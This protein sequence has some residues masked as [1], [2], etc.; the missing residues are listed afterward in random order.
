MTGTSRQRNPVNG[1]LLLDK[2]RG[3]TSQQAVSRVKRLFSA[4]KAGHA[5]TLDPM[6]EGLLPIGLGEAT[7]F[8]QF[9]LDAD[10]CYLATLRL[11]ITTRSGDAEGEILEQK[12]VTMEKSGV[13]AVLH[14]F[15]G[16]QEQTPPMHSAIKIAGK[17]LYAYARAG[18]ELERKSRTIRINELQLIDY[19][20]ENIT[21][22]VHCSKG[23]YIRVLAEDIGAALG[24]GAHL[25][26]LVRE[27][28]GAFRLVDA[29]GLEALEALDNAGR[30]ERLL[31]ADA[32]AGELPKLVLDAEAR[33]R[34]ER[35][36]EV[37]LQVN[38]TGLC[39]LYGIAGD[40]VGVG[41]IGEGGTLRVRRLVAQTAV[42]PQPTLA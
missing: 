34:I 2:P 1:V 30:M 13:D 22:R 15:L 8:T 27:T 10:K 32:F 31:A 40:F 36:R 23:T 5:G 42:S 41:E 35:G 11:G 14:G 37:D 20:D 18:V 28:A 19:I 6:A 7:K 29:V 33:T 21:I 17:P 38:L 4:R 39:R 24:C 26:R 25:T 3:W 16:E 12:P 9:V